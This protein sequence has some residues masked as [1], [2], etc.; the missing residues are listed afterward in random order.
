MATKHRTILAL[1]SILKAIGRPKQ[2]GWVSIWQVKN[3]IRLSEYHRLIR[4]SSGEA[5]SIDWSLWLRF[6]QRYF[7]WGS[8]RTIARNDDLEIWIG[9]A[10]PYST[11]ENFMEL[12]PPI[13]AEREGFRFIKVRN[14]AANPRSAAGEITLI[15]TGGNFPRYKFGPLPAGQ[16]S[17]V[18]TPDNL[19]GGFEV[20]RLNIF[21]EPVGEARLER[22]YG[23]PE[24]L[25]EDK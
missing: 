7:G 20:R 11:A 25:K 5:A 1:R 8:V 15:G 14:A 13:F 16:V 9:D 21:L 4:P 3:L 10:G 18:S 17:H 2:P 24:W 12:H 19:R 23:V 6:G 22:L